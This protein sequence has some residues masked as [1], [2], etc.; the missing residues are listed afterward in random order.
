MLESEDV[1]ADKIFPFPAECGD[2]S[3]DISS[4]VELYLIVMATKAHTKINGANAKTHQQPEASQ[5]ITTAMHLPRQ[6][7]E[8]LRS[9]AFHRAQSSGGRASVSR[10]ITDLVEERRKKLEEEVALK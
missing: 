7:W 2:P 1:I 3:I 9:V 10:L 8:L 4:L 5:S 6:T